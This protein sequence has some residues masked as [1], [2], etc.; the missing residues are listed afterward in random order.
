MPNI[1]DFFPD[2]LKEQLADN[3]FKIGAVLKY[4]IDS[5]TPPKP[6]RLIIVGFDDQKVALATVF[7][8]TEINPNVFPTQALRDLNLE[9]DTINRDYL[10]HK[11]YVNCSQIF[12][13]DVESVKGL[14]ITDPDVH[15]GELNSKDLTEV[16][17]FD[18]LKLH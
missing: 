4:H 11:S 16:L 14:L 3:N 10:D 9:F 18:D 17:H 5:I 13:Q 12:E 2:E 15:I 8:N 7:I 1:G 6:K